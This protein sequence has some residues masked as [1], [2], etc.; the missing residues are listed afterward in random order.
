MQ[1]T[2]RQTYA[3][4]LVVRERRP[5]VIYGGGIRGGKT[6]W[7]LL[8]FVQLAHD[9]PRSR[10]VV[11]RRSLQDLK[12]TTVPSWEA[13]LEQGLRPHVVDF[14]RD[15]WT[16]TFRNGSQLVF[17]G[18][19]YDDDKELNRFRGLECNGIGFDE[20][21]ECQEA[22]FHKGIERAGSW[23]HAQGR[24]PAVVLAT[25][26]PSQ[27]WVR[28]RF[29]DAYLTGTLPAGWEYVP[30]LSDDNPHNDA[31]YLAN[32][33]ASMPPLD[34]DRFVR[35]NWDALRAD[36]AFADEYDEARH[37]HAAAVL[38]PGVPLVISVDWNLNPFGV[39]FGHVWRDAA[40]WHSWTFDEA[41]I[42]NGSVPKMAALI[43]ERY[44]AHLPTAWL[45]GDRGGTAGNLAHFDNASFFTQLRQL[46]GLREAQ[47]RVPP[48]PT[49]DRSR[50][51]CNY[52]LWKSK[53]PSSGLEVLIA[54]GCRGLRRDLASVQCDTTGE[55]VQIRKR[56]RADP[57]QRADLLDCWRYQVNTFLREELERHRAGAGR[58]R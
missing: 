37:V 7:L 17:M 43:R 51:D 9:Y 33:A 20:V 49:H 19:N 11:V 28:G 50:L 57:S 1:L 16:Y 35:G 38:R 2:P 5:V 27:T 56:N 36:N 47:L 45:T 44:A 42:P 46:L 54:P 13:I 3:F 18:E 52:L 26:N 40:G 8:T 15:T 30:S 10:W 22:T 34:Y 6:Y 21:N 48:N 29:Y 53:T 14:D 31:A 23:N 4:D 32:L 41:E 55:R 12:R 25:L 24:P 58:G 39:T